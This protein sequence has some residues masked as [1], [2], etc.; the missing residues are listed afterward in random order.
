MYIYFYFKRELQIYEYDRQFT[1][2]DIDIIHFLYKRQAYRDRNTSKCSIEDAMLRKWVCLMVGTKF[3]LL[4]FFAIF[5]VDIPNSLWEYY[6]HYYFFLCTVDFHISN[7]LSTSN[8]KLKHLK[9][10][11]CESGNYF[12][13]KRKKKWFS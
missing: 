7:K 12:Q 2:R 5:N 11:L 9:C 8:K 13:S 6:Y 10:S 4:Y 3:C 1:W